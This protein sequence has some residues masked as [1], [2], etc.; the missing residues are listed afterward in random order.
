MAC[1]AMNSAGYMQSRMIVVLIDIGQV[2]A[3]GNVPASQLSTYTSN[4]LV[5]NPIQD[6]RDFVK[7][8]NKLLQEGIQDVSKRID[9][10]TRG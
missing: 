2:S 5:S 7:F 4:W 6:V 10:Y 9:E 1:E 8:F 3:G